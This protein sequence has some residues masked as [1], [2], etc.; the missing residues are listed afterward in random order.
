MPI[1]TEKLLLRQMERD[2]KRRKVSFMV[3]AK[4]RAG[5]P[6]PKSKRVSFIAWR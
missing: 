1:H 3:R 2:N 5:E 4:A 6:K